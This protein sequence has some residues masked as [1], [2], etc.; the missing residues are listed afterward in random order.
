MDQFILWLSERH[1]ITLIGFGF[2]FALL[3]FML[4]LWLIRKRSTEN[5]L[6]DLSDLSAKLMQ[7]KIKSE[8]VFRDLEIGL[9]VYGTDGQLTLSNEAALSLLD[10]SEPVMQFDD[11]MTT[12]GED[13]GIKARLLLGKGDATGLLKRSKRVIRMS[14]RVS[15]ADDLRRVANIV[16]IQDITNQE[17]QEKQ[18]KEFVA[19]VSHELKTPL[20]TIAT[21]SESLLDWGL[22]EKQAEGIRKDVLRIHDDAIRMQNLVTDLL[23]L[24]SIDS[25][26]MH[27]RMETMNLEQVVR[28]TVERVQIHAQEKEIELECISLAIGAPV[29][30]DKQSIERIVSNL[31]SNAIK[32]TDRKGVVKVYIGKINDQAYIKVTDTGQGI[33]EQY[34]GRIF[35]RFY[36]VD[37]TGSRLYGGTGLGL[38]IVHELVE[39]HHGQIDV[40]STLGKGSSFTVL[41]PFMNKLFSDVLIDIQAGTLID[42]VMNRAAAEEILLQAHQQ[43]IHLVRLEDLSDAEFD[44]LLSHYQSNEPTNPVIMEELK[45]D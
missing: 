24:S 44:R 18:R 39:L 31:L 7:E 15:R 37:A 9:L 30:G 29:F 3:V 40:Q 4:L 33:E 8:A 5:S 6:R 11:L 20:T 28:Q 16:I 12:F 35:N 10:I 17:L 27:N 43:D 25:Q 34:L 36:R 42:D 21:Y 13:N 2:V 19:N 14:V 45:G 38:S 22:E 32:Y 1:P 23:L 26:K 41:I